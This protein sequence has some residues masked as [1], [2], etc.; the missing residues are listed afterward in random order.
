[1]PT[2]VRCIRASDREWEAWRTASGGNI[3]AWARRHLNAA[4]NGEP[5]ATAPVVHVEPEIDDQPPFV[6]APSPR[7]QVALGAPRGYRPEPFSLVC[8][9]RDRHVRGTYCAACNGDGSSR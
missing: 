5:T 9:D 3:S 7:R 4:A 2:P 8:P 1:M 6:P